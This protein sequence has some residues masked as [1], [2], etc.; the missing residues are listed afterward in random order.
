MARLMIAAR[1]ACVS[2]S[3]EAEAR[4]VR[5]P[6]GPDG[7]PSGNPAAPGAGPVLLLG[8]EPAGGPV[9]DQPPSPSANDVPDPS[10]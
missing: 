9:T 2:T 10:A 8:P 3:L 4:Q 6:L 7:A 1:L 5:P